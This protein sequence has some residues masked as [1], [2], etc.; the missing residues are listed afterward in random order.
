MV[1]VR[2]VHP[3]G[4]QP[5]AV[6]EIKHTTGNYATVEIISGEHILKSKISDNR[7][8][9]DFAGELGPEERA[10]FI[11]LTLKQGL[12]GGIH[13]GDLVDIIYVSFDPIIGFNISKTMMQRVVVLDV[14]SDHGQSVDYSEKGQTMHGIIIVATAQESE[15]IAYCLENGQIYVSKHPYN[16]KIVMTEGIYYENLYKDLRY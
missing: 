6:R 1:E 13:R 15:K 8:S 9:K 14:R 4:I 16:G 12:G 7:D 2:S 5:S 10:I 3:S 11:P